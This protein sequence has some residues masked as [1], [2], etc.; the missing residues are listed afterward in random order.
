[1]FQSLICISGTKHP[2]QSG[3]VRKYLDPG[4]ADTGLEQP[5]DG[6]REEERDVEPHGGVERHGHK[7]TRG[8]HGVSQEHV[9]G[10]GEEEDDLVG[11]EEGGHVETS[12]VGAAQD[13]RDLVP[14]TTCYQ[15]YYRSGS[16]ESNK[17][18]TNK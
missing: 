11:T 4:D 5:L 7:H 3:C 17:I 16:V 10:E 14:K 1:M 12:Q 15:H 13:R 8:R 6:S 2:H 18:N 9:D